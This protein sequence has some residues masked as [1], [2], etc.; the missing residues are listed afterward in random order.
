M[1]QTG[2]QPRMAQDLIT[3]TFLERFVTCK[4]QIITQPHYC[5]TVVLIP[6]TLSPRFVLSSI[7]VPLSQKRPT[8]TQKRPTIPVPLGNQHTILNCTK[9]H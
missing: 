1:Y 9:M 7:P 8:N 4:G 6:P 5:S 3:P 2:K